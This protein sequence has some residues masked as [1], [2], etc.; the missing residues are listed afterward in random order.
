MYGILGFIALVGTFVYLFIKDSNLI[1][2]NKNKKA[3]N[4]MEG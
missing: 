2:F 3:K 1:N 4:I